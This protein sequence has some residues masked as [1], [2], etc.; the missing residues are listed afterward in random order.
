MEEASLA[1]EAIVHQEIGS[2]SAN[3]IAGATIEQVQAI[4]RV[5]V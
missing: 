1:L 2:V 4:S 3:R 5:S